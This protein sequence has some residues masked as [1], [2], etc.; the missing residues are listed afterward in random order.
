MYICMWYVYK[1]SIFFKYTFTKLA[2]ARRSLSV[3]RGSSS[4]P[5]FSLNL[6]SARLY[7]TILSS[8]ISTVLGRPPLA[9][10]EWWWWRWWWGGGTPDVSPII[11]MTVFVPVAVV[12]VVGGSTLTMTWLDGINWPFS[13]S[14]WGGW[15]WGWWWLLR[16]EDCAAINLSVGWT[17]NLL[18]VF[19]S[20]M[21]S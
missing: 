10:F 7:Y 14:R 3:C 11:S 8:S 16:L 18:A 5:R 19:V 4:I 1:Y 2:L 9:S 13:S 20:P 6:K 15:G 21:A 17:S 12:A